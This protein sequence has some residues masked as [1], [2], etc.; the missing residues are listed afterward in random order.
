MIAD[1]LNRAAICEEF[2]GVIH[3]AGLDGGYCYYERSDDG[4]ATKSTFADGSTRRLVT[5][6]LVDEEQPGIEV[7]RH[8][9]IL[10]AVTEE[11]VVRVY[12]SW[13]DGWGWE[14][15]GSVE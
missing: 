5:T 14:I 10:V 3:A 11:D 2:G 7:T 1:D 8:G 13:T 15:V 9:M 6:D 12:R 4:G